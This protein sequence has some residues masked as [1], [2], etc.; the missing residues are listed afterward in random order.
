MSQTLMVE[1]EECPQ[2]GKSTPAKDSPMSPEERCQFVEKLYRRHEQD[3]KHYLYRFFAPS[4]G[5][6]DDILQA[7]F[8]QLIQFGGLHQVRYPRAF[9]FRTAT[10]IALRKLSKSRKQL[11]LQDTDCAEY[12]FLAATRNCADMQLLMQQHQQLQNDIQEMPDKQ[13]QIL[14]R[15]RILGETYREIAL[16]CNWS[17]ADIC[18]TLKRT[19]SALRTRVLP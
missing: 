9:L 3:L 18:R 16:C 1:N 19:L 15:S 11:E 8:L 7:A 12:L 2:N 10:N 13:R 6:T 14:L 5:E 17:Q 4:S